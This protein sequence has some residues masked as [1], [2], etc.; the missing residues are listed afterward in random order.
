MKRLNL[1]FELPTPWTGK[2]FAT[3][4]VGFVNYLVGPNGS[5][6]SRF[7]ETLL[8][9]LGSPY[10]RLLGTDRLR[11]LEKNQG[12]GFL[13]S[14]FEQGLPKSWFQNLKRAGSLG[15][16]I[17]SIILLSEKL[18]LRVRIEATLSNL[19]NRRIVLDWDAGNLVPKA[20]LGSGE[21]YRLDSDEC[22]GIKELTVLLTHLYDDSSKFLIIDEPELHLHP[23]FQAFLMQEIRKAAGDPDTGKK[24]IFLIT[25]SPFI[26]DFH[27]S[28]TIRSVIS[29]DINH[30][31]P[32]HLFD[33]DDQQAARLST[34]IPRLNA[35]NKQLFFSDNPIFVEG[36]LD[37]QIIRAIKEKKYESLAAAG[38]CIIDAGGNEEI[39]WYLELCSALLKKAHYVY[40]LDSLFTGTLRRSVQRD[41]AVTGFLLAAGL[42][43]SFAAYCGQLDSKLHDAAKLIMST[44][45]VSPEISRLKARLTELSDTNGTFE[46][47]KLQKARV[48]ILVAVARHRSDLIGCIGEVSVTEIEGILGQVVNALK[49]KNI[50][51]LSAGALEHYLP[52]YAGDEYVLDEGTKRAAIEKELT[53]LAQDAEADLAGRYGGLY[54]VI[55]SLPSKAD[56]NLDDILR[57][58]LSRYIHEIQSL[59]V[60]RAAR[61]M[62]DVNA[63][64]R[65]TFPGWDRLFVLESLGVADVD[66]F[67]G[68]I[69]VIGLAGARKRLVDFS[70]ATNAGMRD[71]AFRDAPPQQRS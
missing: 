5:G 71:F 67:F 70:N 50:L 49:E 8:G 24:C 14:S 16:G 4:R 53:W 43:K 6:K 55:Q 44:P 68:S 7:G 46:K 19:F 59:I 64:L 66:H 40:D 42:G 13:G 31:A 3:S 47:E 22:H 37:A 63:H 32:R 34:L 1:D 38:S 52:S 20:I 45:S 21:A 12:M 65:T 61:T 36:I 57:Q 51:L 54:A 39:N 56:V 2:R 17:D 28:G 10:A 15:F 27:V 30:S 69:S 23:Q 26:L 41:D 9:A 18:D 62:S 25:H 29:F 58:Y 11:G 35:N 33:V 60:S 48:V